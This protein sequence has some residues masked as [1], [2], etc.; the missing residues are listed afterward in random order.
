MIPY[1]PTGVSWEVTESGNEVSFEWN[2]ERDHN[3]RNRKFTLQWTPD[4]KPG[5][6]SGDGAGDG[7]IEHFDASAGS[8]YTIDYSVNINAST[9]NWATDNKSNLAVVGVDGGITFGNYRIR[10]HASKS[11]IF[12]F[13]HSGW[14][15]YGIDEWTPVDGFGEGT[16]MNFDINIGKAIETFVITYVDQSGQ[17]TKTK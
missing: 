5:D 4:S 17:T 16:E 1:N 15:S 11:G 14:K 12:E 9:I 7:V 6:G 10:R 8:K 13:S 2:R 3:I